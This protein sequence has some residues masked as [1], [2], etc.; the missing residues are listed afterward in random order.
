MA[1]IEH[2][3]DGEDRPTVSAE[4]RNIVKNIID[5]ALM[6]A[7]NRPADAHILLIQVI[8]VACQVLAKSGRGHTIAL[9]DATIGVLQ[10]TRDSLKI[11]GG[12]RGQG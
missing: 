11:G 12:E 3:P 9:F 1:G 10:S 4:I 7:G 5:T 2:G 6:A 8:A